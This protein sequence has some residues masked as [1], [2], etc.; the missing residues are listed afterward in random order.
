[1]ETHEQAVKRGK[2]SRKAGKAFEVLTRKQLT[3]Q[4]WNVCRWDNQVEL[5]S[6]DVAYVAKALEKSKDVGVG[7]LPS[8]RLIQA[9]GKFNPFT[10]RVMNMSGGMPDFL[11]VRCKA[12][13]QSG[14]VFSGGVWNID[15]TSYFAVQ[16]VECKINNKLDKEEK[17]KMA[18]LEEN[19]KIPCFVAYPEKEG[20]KT[21]VKLRRWNE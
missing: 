15:T 6:P 11:C 2:T 5:H 8:G 16:L 9:K 21:I 17:E 7:C 12:E 14:M 4:G 3:E 20:R 1:M 10:K 18:W 19:L 13:A